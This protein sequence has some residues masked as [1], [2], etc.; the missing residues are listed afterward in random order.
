[1][2]D[3]LSTIAYARPLPIIAWN[4]G[5]QTMEQEK[6]SDLDDKSFTPLSEDRTALPH[7][8]VHEDEHS[9]MIHYVIKPGE[10]TGWHKHEL[11]YVVV[12][13]SE[14]TLT[15]NFADGTKRHFAYEP[16]TTSSFKAP[17][18]HNAVN[19]GDTDIIGY[20]IEFK[21]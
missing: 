19:T 16:G 15:S 9:R 20:E 13:V 11:D 4:C 2:A 3:F 12:R 1:V 7:I 10:Q 18:E 5:Q 21:S 17:V 8:V 14:G 6:M